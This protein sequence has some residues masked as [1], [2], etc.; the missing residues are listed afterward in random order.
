M[1]KNIAVAIDVGG[2]CNRLAV[3]RKI[4]AADF[5]LVLRQPVNFLGRDLEQANVLVAIAGIARDQQMLPVRRKVT[6]CVQTLTLVR[7]HEC[8]LRSRNFGHED[9]RVRSLGLKLCIRDPLTVFRPDRASSAAV[10]RGGRGQV[11]HLPHQRVVNV[12][13]VGRRRFR[14]D[15]VGE[16]TAIRRP[17]RRL[18]RNFSRVGEIDYLSCLGRDEKNVPLLVAVI[19]RLVSHPLAVRRTRRRKLALLADRQLRRPAAFR[20]HRPQIHSAADVADEHD[21]FSIRRPRT[22]GYK[23]CHVKLFDRKILLHLR[24]RLA[25]NLLG[26][27]DRL[28][29]GQRLGECNRTHTHHDNKGKKSSHAGLVVTPPSPA[30]GRRDAGAT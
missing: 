30:A 11:I 21:C 6:G 25:G 29:R 2:P 8:A 27:G 18:L 28:R 3:R 17:G 9:V 4:P 16:K 26:I 19:I 1:H 20:G 15:C 22:P 10:L 5:P 13:L 23:P 7:R 12:N 14:L 24:V